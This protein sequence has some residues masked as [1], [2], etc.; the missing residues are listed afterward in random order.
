MNIIT[1]HR[2]PAPV[3][4]EQS[5]P[6][7][8]EVAKLPDGTPINAALADWHDLN[9]VEAALN[10]VLEALT[11]WRAAVRDRQTR[12]DN[13]RFGIWNAHRKIERTAAL[14][15][16]IEKKIARRE[17]KF[18]KLTSAPDA[19]ARL[20]G[21]IAA[22]NLT[23]SGLADAVEALEEHIEAAT[24]QLAELEREKVEVPAVLQKFGC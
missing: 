5:A 4:I 8:P 6:A 17:A 19:L 16:N 11:K 22:F 18:G 7:A 23:I 3:T 21:E 13:L 1:R 10:P 9:R 24:A 14:E 20:S 12:A 15:A 2:E